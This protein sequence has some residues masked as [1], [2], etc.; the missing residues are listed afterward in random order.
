M[1]EAGIGYGRDIEEEHQITQLGRQRRL[2]GERGLWWHEI[3]FFAGSFMDHWE[4]EFW[5]NVPGKN[6]YRNAHVTQGDL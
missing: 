4:W 5:S 1:M 2:P 3:A 6:T